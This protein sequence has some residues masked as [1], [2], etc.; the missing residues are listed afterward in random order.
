MFKTKGAHDA[1]FY[2]DAMVFELDS[3]LN[4]NDK[5]ISIYPNCLLFIKMAM[6]KNFEFQKPIS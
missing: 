2:K 3:G 6:T 4:S 1:H 5:H